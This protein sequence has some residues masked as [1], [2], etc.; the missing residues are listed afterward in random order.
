MNLLGFLAITTH[1]RVL[2]ANPLLMFP[3]RR[4]AVSGAPTTGTV[5]GVVALLPLPW[6]PAGRACG[7]QHLPPLG[8]CPARGLTSALISGSTKNRVQN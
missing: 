7:H 2:G 5:S 8:T 4:N 1:P 6:H 3:G